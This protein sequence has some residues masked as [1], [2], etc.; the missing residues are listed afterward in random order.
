MLLGKRHFRDNW[1][2][3]VNKTAAKR[4]P[5]ETLAA[6]QAENNDVARTSAAR[7]KEQS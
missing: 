2:N 4:N 5:T 7:P 1:R 3:R 6:L